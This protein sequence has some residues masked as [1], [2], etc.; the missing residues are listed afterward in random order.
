M[1][2]NLGESLK[3]IGGLSKP[4][5]MPWYSWSTSAFDCKTGSQLRKVENSTCAACYALKGNY[6]W[7]NVKKA[8]QNRLRALDDPRFVEAF[9]NVL[10]ILYDKSRKTYML[11]GKEIKENR[12]RWHDSGDLQSVDHL[13]MINEIALATPFLKHWLPTREFGI[14]N[15]YLKK[16]NTFAKNLIVRMSA[17]IVGEDFPRRPMGLPYSTVGVDQVKN[18]CPAYEQEG[19]CLDCSTCWD[20]RKNVNYP[21]H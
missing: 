6:A 4:S 3:I 18:Q 15:D 13:K 2:M 21:L 5:K 20:G 12:F 19:K 9:I 8:H 11:N 1:S 14:V 16:G 10:T 7:P 17:V